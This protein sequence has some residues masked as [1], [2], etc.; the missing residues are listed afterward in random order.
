MR[1]HPALFDRLL[2][3][4][5]ALEQTQSLL[6]LLKSRYVDQIRRWEPVLSDENRS[7]IGR[8]LT[9]QFGC[10]ALQGGHKFGSH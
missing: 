2:T 1:E 5:D 4:R 10:L 7:A 9:Q 3:A 6:K 8:E